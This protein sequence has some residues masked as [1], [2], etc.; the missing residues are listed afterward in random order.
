MSF[1]RKRDG[2]LRSQERKTVVGFRLSV[3]LRSLRDEW[4]NKE[5]H[6]IFGFSS[7]S[8]YFRE[9]G[10]RNRS[11]LVHRAEETGGSVLFHCFGAL[12]EISRSKGGC[13][14]KFRASQ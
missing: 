9:L 5:R 10:R 14:T 12:K 6:S 11:L 1:P 2:P 3:I 13:K 8:S 7:S 4:W